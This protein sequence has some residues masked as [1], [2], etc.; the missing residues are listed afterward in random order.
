MTL[1]FDKGTPLFSQ[2][3]DFRMSSFNSVIVAAYPLLRPFL[4]S[5]GPSGLSYSGNSLQMYGAFGMVSV[6]K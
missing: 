4:F 1:I 5:Y 2:A 3:L 6:W